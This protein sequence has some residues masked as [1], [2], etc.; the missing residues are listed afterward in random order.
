[1]ER[2]FLSKLS[3]C[4]LLP[5]LIF[6][7]RHRKGM[8]LTL[9]AAAHSLPPASHRTQHMSGRG[10]GSWSIPCFLSLPR[11]LWSTPGP[12][13]TESSALLLLHPRTLASPPRGAQEA[14]DR[15]TYSDLRLALSLAWNGRPASLSL[16]PHLPGLGHVTA[17]D[18]AC[19]GENP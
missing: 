14:P 16:A 15:P 7:E 2:L 5:T 10:G 4:F 11:A 17:G 6:S 3:F 13:V 18:V 12:N 8:T 9:M 1:M 19:P